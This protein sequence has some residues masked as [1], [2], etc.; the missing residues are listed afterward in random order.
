MGREHFGF[1]TKLL[2]LQKFQLVLAHTPSLVSVFVFSKKLHSQHVTDHSEHGDYEI[3]WACLL[4]R[5]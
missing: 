2:D 5:T 1:F 3:D 4:E